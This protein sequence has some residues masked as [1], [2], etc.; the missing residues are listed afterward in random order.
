MTAK[1]AR[2]H[3]I[4]LG[5]EHGCRC[6]RCT[7]AEYAYVRALWVAKHGDDSKRPHLVGP[8]SGHVSI[9]AD[10]LLK[11]LARDG[12]PRVMF[13]RDA[14]L[15]KSA[16]YH[17]IRRGRCSGGTFDALCSALD[18]NGYEITATA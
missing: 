7:A 17:V 2:R 14:G 4:Y 8:R 16:T 15:S 1:V 10:E 11:R 9:D 3:G 18:I 13:E 6:E 12:R 5:Y